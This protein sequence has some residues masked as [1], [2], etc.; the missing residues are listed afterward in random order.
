[1]RKQDKLVEHSNDIASRL[2][3]CENDSAL[4]VLSKVDKTFNDIVG[5]IGIE[6]CVLG[7]K[8]VNKKDL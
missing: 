4:I 7:S 6:T 8:S 3:N 2:V 1:M 5:I